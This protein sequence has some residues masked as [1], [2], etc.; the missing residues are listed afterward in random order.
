MLRGLFLD[1]HGQASGNLIWK[2]IAQGVMTWAFLW[3][4]HH[5]R[6]NLE[7]FIAYGGMVGSLNY[8]GKLFID[9]MAKGKKDG[10]GTAE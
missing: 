9:N 10:S 8:L 2:F 5:G 4:V 7:L 6:F 1:R 3:E